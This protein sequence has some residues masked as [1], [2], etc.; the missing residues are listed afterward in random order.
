MPSKEYLA[1]QDRF[2]NLPPD[3]F[4]PGFNPGGPMQG[5]P[6]HYPGAELGV[7]VFPKDYRAPVGEIPEGA[8]G[9]EIYLNGVRGL[10][11][12]TPHVKPKCAFLYL[13]GGGFTIGSAMTGGPLMKLFADR[14]GLEGYACDYRLAPWYKHP[15]EVEDA[16][17]F[18]KGLLEL[19]Y[20]HIV[21]GGESAGATLTLCLTFAL[22]EQG[23]PLPKVLWCSSPPS[24]LE[25]YKKEL[26]HMD[27][28]ADSGEKVKAAYAPDADPKDPLVSPYY[29]DFAGMP[30]MM[31]QTGGGES[32]GAGAVQLAVQAAKANCE[33]VLHYGQSMPHTFAM[34]YLYYPEAANAME[35]ILTFVNQ[36][37]AIAME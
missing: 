26:Y 6:N 8:T 11:L 29:G 35:E 33:V 13:H 21:V 10:H 25:W 30:P 28:F 2:N 34:D 4:P 20:E 27:F 23:L 5:G 36:R 12:T 22:K 14:C 15:A 1:F 18:Y 31:I 24:E 19:G 17:E 3:E 16:V 9:E 32:L 7:P 37:L